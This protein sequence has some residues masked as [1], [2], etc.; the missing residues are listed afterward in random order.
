MTFA[1][2]LPLACLSAFSYLTMRLS[3]AEPAVIQR[4][5]DFEGVDTRSLRPLTF[6]RWTDEEKQNAAQYSKFE[7]A[8]EGSGKALR[9][10]ILQPL[11]KGPSYYPLW[12]TG[13]EY[14]TPEADAIRMRVKVVSGGFRLTVG[15]PTAYFGT[16]D[17]HAAPQVLE[18][19]DWHTLEFSLITHLERNYRRP[20]FSQEAPVIYYTRWIQEPMR[21]VMSAD[22]QGELLLDDMELLSYGRGRPFPTFPAEAVRVLGEAD[23]GTRFTF[24]TDD[25]EFD[26]SHT[27][28][29]EALRKPA[30]LTAITEGRGKW[31]ARQRGAEEMSFFGLKTHAPK[32]ANAVRLTLKME[33]ASDLKDL[34]FDL[35]ALVG[36]G[37]EF[38]WDKTS[39]QE[40]GTGNSTAKPASGEKGFDYCLSP[41]RTRGISRGFYHARRAVPKGEWTQVIIPFADFVCA[42]GA[43]TLKERHLLQQPLQPGEITAVALLSPWRQNDADTLFTIDK[44]EFVSVPGTPSQHVSYPQVPDVSKVR[45]EKVAGDYGSHARQ[46]EGP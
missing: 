12:S 44:I 15:G 31:T 30:V 2:L 4:I 35:I 10:S 17:V 27:P 34:A 3:A 38:P 33:H 45:L 36:P 6:W 16:S 14:L 42:Y 40:V 28:G 13:L 22:S 46:V 7:L 43:G 9:I 29:K 24:A 25:R 41:A 5:E 19:G 23:A 11:P 26:L 32:E 21:L 37:G 1:R 8:P 18:P 39:P 20:I